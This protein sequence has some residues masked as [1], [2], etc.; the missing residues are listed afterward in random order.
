MAI[1][2]LYILQTGKPYHC[3]RRSLVFKFKAFLVLS[4]KFFCIKCR[5]II[6]NLNNLIFY[7]LVGTLKAT[8]I[9]NDVK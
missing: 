9:E 3:L 5:T 2:L 7:R 1:H 6:L 4:L 8:T